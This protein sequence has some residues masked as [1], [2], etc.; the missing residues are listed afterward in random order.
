MW[1]ILMILTRFPEEGLPQ[2]TPSQQKTNNRN[3]DA[4]PMMWGL[5]MILTRFPEEGLPQIFLEMKRGNF[6]HI[7]NDP[8]LE[9][10]SFKKKLRQIAGLDILQGSF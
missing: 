7:I 3:I 6:Y 10:G 4:S 5:L 8:Y 2:K 1:G 9:N